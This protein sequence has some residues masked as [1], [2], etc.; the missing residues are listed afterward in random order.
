MLAT[1]FEFPESVP[2]TDWKLNKSA[3]LEIS[4]NSGFKAARKYE[5]Q[6]NSMALEIEMRYA[7]DTIGQVEGMMKGHTFSSRLLVN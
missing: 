7:V 5:Y 1:P 3:P 6:K 2:L 4:D